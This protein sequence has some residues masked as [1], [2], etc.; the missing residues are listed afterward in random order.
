V[1]KS[2]NSTQEN[3]Q[4][5]AGPPGRPK[6]QAWRDIAKQASKEMDGEK[7]TILIAELCSTFDDSNKPTERVP[8]H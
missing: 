5:N 6:D 4:I 8:V 2:F 7:L 1:T 3:R